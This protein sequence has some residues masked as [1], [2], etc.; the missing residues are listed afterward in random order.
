ME[1]LKKYHKLIRGTGRVFQRLGLAE[2]DKSII[3]WKATRRLIR[4]IV[5]RGAR[6][7]K[8]S[9]KIEGTFAGQALVD[10]L[11]E[12]ANI[13]GVDVEDFACQLLEALGLLRLDGDD[14]LR[15]MP[16]LAQ[17]IVDA[18]DFDFGKILTK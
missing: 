10:L 2:L 13:H 4:L 17:Y 15:P 3:G 8:S 5:E 1:Y 12:A 11:L 7:L 16:L 14:E 18:G 6:P 9:T